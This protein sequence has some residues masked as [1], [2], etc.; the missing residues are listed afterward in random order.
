[1]DE[2]HEITWKARFIARLAELFVRNGLDANA[3]IADAH[4][5]SQ[6][7]YLHRKDADPVGE[8]EALHR[9][10]QNGAG[11]GSR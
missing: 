1:M 2:L 3:A 5:H 6:D 11:L 9:E 8:A 10:L 4:A 7:C